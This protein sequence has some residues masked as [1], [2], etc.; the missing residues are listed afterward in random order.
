M[1]FLELLE[2]ASMPVIQVLL[3][4]AL[5]AFMA[6]HYFNNLLSSEFRKS[7]NKV[8]FFVL[9]PSLVF[10]SFAK[11]VSLE[12]MISWWFMPVN[13]GLTFLIGGILGWI[14]VKL[15]KP[16]LKVE[17][18][19]IAA[20]S[21]GNMGN[22]PIVIIPAICDE[23][24]APFGAHDVCRSHALSYASF[25]MALGG[26]FIWTYTY[27]TIRSRS[28]RFKELEATQII[29]APNKDLEGNA[30]TPLLKGKDDESTAI[31]VA[32]S[33]YIEDAESQ[34]IVQQDV[35]KKENQSFLARTIEVLRDL[36]EELM[37]P[38]AIATFFG[39]LFGGVAWLRNLIIGAN[40][41][42]RVIQDSLVL[43]GNG[44]IPCI[45]LLLGGNLTQGLKSSSVK[46][47]TLISIIIT[48]LLV[49]PVIGLFIV[50]A[51][52]NFGLLPVDPLFQYTLVMQYAMPPAMNISTMAQLFDVGNEECS[53]I[54]LW[55][56][57]AAAIALTAWSTFLLWL[58]SN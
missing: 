1:G 3:I 43:L 31:E 52:A 56:Y 55:T 35:L 18:L 27:Q 26:I 12:D 37:S 45:T 9:T 33:S 15:L 17:G 24:G 32:P 34:I 29:K 36:V 2:A 48:R 53:V 25:S 30:N 5:G 58:L 40:A 6:T 20:C 46:P 11:S 38:P 42:L 22:L 41:P 47:L 39:F 49:L 23:K 10:S 16:N 21:S 50:K 54:L 51:A 44:T 19:I 8:V 57:S 14:L 28:M 4:S 13:V 7:L